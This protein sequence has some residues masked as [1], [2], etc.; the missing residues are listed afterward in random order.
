MGTWAWPLTMPQRLESGTTCQGCRPRAH[1]PLDGRALIKCPFWLA[2]RT[3]VGDFMGVSNSSPERPRCDCGPHRNDV[4]MRW[5]ILDLG[6]LPC[7]INLSKLNQGPSSRASRWP[8]ICQ[9][10]GDFL[11]NLLAILEHALSVLRSH[12][13]P[14]RYAF[15]VSA[16]WLALTT[17]PLRIAREQ[18]KRD[19][20][21]H[22]LREAPFAKRLPPLLVPA[23][24]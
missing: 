7:L 13:H 9:R 12:L 24:Y 3:Q 21:A 2:S 6:E 15:R 4:Q 1:T 20:L 5:L 17:G 19:W 23:Q 11:R 16:S 18:A 22:R 10:I 14:L 8:S